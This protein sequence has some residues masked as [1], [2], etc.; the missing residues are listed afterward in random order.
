MGGDLNAEAGACDNAAAD[1]AK[2]TEHL[3]PGRLSQ[4]RFDF[5]IRAWNLTTPILWPFKGESAPG[6]PRPVGFC[7][8]VESS[9]ALPDGSNLHIG[10]VV[11]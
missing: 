3:S 10:L 11:F 2:W 8:G 9:H 1:C 7:S 5:R 6:E 4:T